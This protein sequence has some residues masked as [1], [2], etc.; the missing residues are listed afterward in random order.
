MRPVNYLQYAFK[1]LG[2]KLFRTFGFPKMM[3]SNCVFS[4]TNFC[5]SKCK[6]C[7]IWE[8]YPNQ[9]ELAKKEMTTEQWLKT[10]K[11][12]GPSVFCVFTGGEPFLRNDAHELLMGIQKYKKPKILTICTNATLPERIEEVLDKFLQTKK[13]DIDL[14][15]NISLDHIGEKHDEIRGIK[16]NWEKL[17]E[18]VKVVRKLQ[19]KYGYPNLCFHTVVSKW[20][21]D[22]IPKIY[23]YVV[24]ELKPDVYI[25]EPSELRYELGT[26]NTD[27]LPDKEKLSKVFRVYSS[28]KN[29]TF[30]TNVVRQIYIDKYI[31]GQ[32]LPCYASFNHTQI[33]TNGNVWTCCMMADKEPLGNL[34]EADFDFK[35]IW[36]S[37]RANKIR[38]KVKK[39]EFPTCKGCY[40][41]V[42]ANTSIPQNIALTTKYIL[43]ELFGKK[44]SKNSVNN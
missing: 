2:Y 9:P 11:T 18:T 17:L 16:G 37:K 27:I 26:I 30:L 4:V 19:D 22:D 5:N 7:H 14:T 20:N 10:F 25:M 24:N 23:D 15:I 1:I 44:K 29:V 41:A 38:K 6:T 35:K 13:K 43:R 39:R 21:V 34:N 8:K 36:F 32:G 3:P 12:M 28:N 40:L 31:K 42:A 33:T